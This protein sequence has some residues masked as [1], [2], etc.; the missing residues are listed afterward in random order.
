MFCCVVVLNIGYRVTV[1]PELESVRFSQF[2]TTI[3]DDGR[4]PR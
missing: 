2:S 1:E 4:S 3:K